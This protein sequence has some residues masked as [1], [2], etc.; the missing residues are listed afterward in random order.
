MLRGFAHLL[1]SSGFWIGRL[2]TDETEPDELPGGPLS[3][4]LRALSGRVVGRSRVGSFGD[5]AVAALGVFSCS[6]YS[7][8]PLLLLDG[9][10]MVDDKQLDATA[11]DAPPP[12]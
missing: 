11:A 6:L 10:I 9:L 7:S 5:D 12:S 4:M 1:Q 8:P 2:D 3:D